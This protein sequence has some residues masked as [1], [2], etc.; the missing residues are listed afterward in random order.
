LAALEAV[1]GSS[2]L[3]AESWPLLEREARRAGVT[4]SDNAG[5]VAWGEATLPSEPGGIREAAS[6]MGLIAALTRHDRLARRRRHADGSPP[7]EPA[8]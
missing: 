4:V 3:G 8:A 5:E 7:R 2:R 6:V 1:L